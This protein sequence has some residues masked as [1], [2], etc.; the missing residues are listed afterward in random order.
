MKSSIILMIAMA[1]EMIKGKGIG[2]FLS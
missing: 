2:I 1:D